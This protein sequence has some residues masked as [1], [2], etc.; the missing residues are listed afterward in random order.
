M[1]ELN[2]VLYFGIVSVPVPVPFPHKF[3]LNKP[4]GF[5]YTRAKTKAI[6]AVALMQTVHWIHYE[7]NGSDVA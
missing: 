1:W 7:P 6:A 3:C 2:W 5:I 4:L